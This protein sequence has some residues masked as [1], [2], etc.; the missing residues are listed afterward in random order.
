[1]VWLTANG[2]GSQHTQGGRQEEETSEGGGGEGQGLRDHL[3]P[4]RVLLRVGPT[5]MK[6]QELT[7]LLSQSLLLIAINQAAELISDLPQ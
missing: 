1:M 7:H 2:Q 5:V 3:A 4:G 6:P